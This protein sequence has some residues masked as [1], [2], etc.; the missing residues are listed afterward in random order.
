MSNEIE[1]LIIEHHKLHNGLSTIEAENAYLENAMKISLYGIYFFKS[2]DSTGKDILIGVTTLGVIVYQNDHIVNEFSW[3]KMMKISFK[4]RTF[5][6]ELKRELSENYDTILGF[7]MST[8]KHAK[9][10]WKTCVEYHSFFRLKRMTFSTSRHLNLTK[11]YLTNCLQP[12]VTNESEDKTT[13]TFNKNRTIVENRLNEKV[14][15]SNSSGN[16]NGSVSV[17]GNGNGKKSIISIA[18]SYKTYDNKI[19]SKQVESLPRIAWEQQK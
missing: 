3:S 4:R 5:F 6:M 15:N 17:N 7:K 12:S 8:H 14:A 16:G 13:K 9:A 1:Y 10:I 18:K 19:T 2:K 11:I